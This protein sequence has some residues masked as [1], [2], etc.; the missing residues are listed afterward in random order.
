[1][2]EASYAQKIQG[3]FCKLYSGPSSEARK[4]LKKNR[5]RI[6]QFLTVMEGQWSAQKIAPREQIRLEREFDPSGAISHQSRITK[7]L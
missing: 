7:Q 5:P 1:M 2:I 3:D 4:Q 6:C